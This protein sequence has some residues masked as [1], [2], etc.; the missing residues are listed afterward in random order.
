MR[1]SPFLENLII[2][3]NFMLEAADRMF[4]SLNDTESIIRN[5]FDN[6]EM[7]PEFY[8]KIEFYLNL[9]FLS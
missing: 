7:I 6:R 8:S 9:N 4:C 2:L 3:Q 5:L 1:S